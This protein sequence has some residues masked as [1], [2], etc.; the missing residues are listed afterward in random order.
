MA[1]APRRS[2]ISPSND[3]STNRYP[4]WHNIVAGAA[5]G[6]GARLLTAPLDLLKIRRQIATVSTEAVVNAAKPSLLQTAKQIIQN[7][8]GV[9]GLFR[10]N[11]AATYLW[12]GYVVVQFSLYARTSDYLKNVPAPKVI[13]VAPPSVPSNTSIFQASS[14]NFLKY[15]RNACKTLRKDIASRPTS[16]AFISGATAG[17]CATVAT[18][19][20][21]ICRTAF[22]AQGVVKSTT[23]TAAV[24]STISNVQKVTQQTPPVTTLS[25]FAKRMVSQH[26]YRG[27]YAGC[28]P[29]VVQIIP[30][31]GINFALYD[32]FTRFSDRHNV[33][34]AGVAGTIAGGVSKIIVYPLD[35][36]KKR[37]QAQTFASLLPPPSLGTAVVQS[38][39]RYH[40]KGMVD[41]IL[42]TAK[43][44][45]IAGFYRG[46][47]PT[48]MKNA[49]ATGF[50]FAFFTLAK[51][52]LEAVDDSRHC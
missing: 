7:E 51:N 16:V 47:V 29:A 38:Q 44:E 20:F 17:V 42:Q 3:P 11:I 30:Y 12:V 32:I 22:A 46:L 14:I 50:T 2:K 39:Y 23:T 24:S 19:P 36:V 45:G 40:Y 8:G 13:P 5:A 9:R 4:Q 34:N 21:D 35:T 48:V 49:A 27:F 28:Y 41:C 6:A 37:L 15:P 10:G 25:Q 26:G 33:V 1:K 43:E 52:M 31:M 18:Y